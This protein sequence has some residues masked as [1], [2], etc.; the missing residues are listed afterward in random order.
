MS[1]RTIRIG[2]CGLGTV[3]QGVWKHLSANRSA[4]E[5]RLGVRIELA[6]AAVRD[7]RKVRTVNV[8]A[9][10]LVA[11]PLSIATDPSID[12]VCELMGG[13]GLAKEVTL[14]ALNRGKV[15]VSANKALLCEHGA[16]V[17][18]AARKGG[19]HFFFEASVAGGIPIIKAL[20]EGLVANRFKLIYGILNGTC[21]YILTR[22]AAEGAGY[23]QILADAKRLGYAEADESLDVEGWDTAHKAA[24]LAYLAHG[25]WV[26]T[27]QMIVDGIT[28]ITQ[29]DLKY[30]ATL[31]YGI[32]LLAVITRDFERNELFVRVHPTLIPKDRVLA[33]VNGVFNGIAVMGDVVGT[34]TYIGRGAGQDATASAVISDIADAIVLLNTGRDVTPVAT[35]AGVA[36][37]LS[38]PVQAVR[39]SPLERI[40]SRYYVRTTV[41]DRPGVLAQIATVMA[42]N[43]VSIESVI[44]T[45]AERPAAASLI[46]TTHESD[47]KAMR[48]TLA[49]LGRLKSVV[50][51]PLLLRIGDFSE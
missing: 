17:F 19:G 20:R 28:Q 6:K 18:A 42:R 48:A 27:P 51:K 13:T 44:Q 21:N 41:K 12:I 31:G 1:S 36:E 9:G 16:T 25:V 46:L 49:A 39:L 24:I 5:A 3:G 22:M 4:L 32:K 40:R 15:V 37:L 8:P 47:E 7:P 23:P 43:G 26:K 10:K 38:V 33:N 2:L 11:D 30:A 50:E 45:S 34:T 29:A 35:T 14:A